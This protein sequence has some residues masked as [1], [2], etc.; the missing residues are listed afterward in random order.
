MHIIDGNNFLGL[1]GTCLSASRV[2]CLSFGT[3]FLPLLG[4]DLI[5]QLHV[6]CYSSLT[7]SDCPECLRYHGP[8]SLLTG[9]RRHHL[10]F[11][12]Y[13][14]TAIIHGVKPAKLRDSGCC[15]SPARKV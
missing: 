11:C 8:S 7:F 14:S 6:E 4:I 1:L 10:I 3:F 9:M 2:Y 12:S 15:R 13:S 5:N